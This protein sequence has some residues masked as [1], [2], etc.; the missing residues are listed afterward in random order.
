MMME[1]K[2]LRPWSTMGTVMVAMTTMVMV[3]PS[4]ATRTLDTCSRN[5]S[6]Q[7]LAC[8]VVKGCES[9]LGGDLLPSVPQNLHLATVPSANG[10]ALVLRVAWSLP[11]DASV[12]SVTGFCVKVKVRDRHESVSLHFPRPPAEQRDPQGRPWSFTYS[13]FSV[14]PGEF[15]YVSVHSQPYVESASANYT[16]PVCTDPNLAKFPICKK[17]TALVSLAVNATPGR[18]LV[19]YRSFD[20]RPEYNV[21]LCHLTFASCAGAAP[22]RTLTGSSN[23]SEFIIEQ[24]MPCLCVEVYATRESSLRIQ[25]CPFENVTAEWGAL[26][27]SRAP[28]GVTLRADGLLRRCVY[29]VRATLLVRRGGRDT[30]V[31]SAT[32]ERQENGSIILGFALNPEVEDQGE[33]CVMLQADKFYAPSDVVCVPRWRWVPLLALGAVVLAG[34][35]LTALGA[36]LGHAPGR[37]FGGAKESRM[38][39]LLHAHEDGADR[40]PSSLLALVGAL[41][42]FLRRRC[43]AEV[44]LDAWEKR[45]VARLGP[46]P[47]LAG[48]LERCQLSGGAVVVLASGAARRRWD[49]MRGLRHPPAGRGGAGDPASSDDAGGATEL[50]D[51]FTPALRLLCEQDAA[52]RSANVMVAVCV[53][54]GDVPSCL[55]SARIFRLPGDLGRLSAAIGGGGSVRDGGGGRRLR[56]TPEGAALLAEISKARERASGRGGGA[57]PP[58]ATD[59]AAERSAAGADFPGTAITE[60]KLQ[61]W[62]FLPDPSG[63]GDGETDSAYSSLEPA[64]LEVGGFRLTRA[65]LLQLVQQRS[66]KG[67][68][69]PCPT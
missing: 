37:F 2:R 61:M 49:E 40:P 62:P 51:L 16:V 60:T 59:A 42:T 6:Q 11:V 25:K 26:R 15:V 14:S 21:R 43:G 28:G 13:C 10:K 5:C 54:G 3:I 66:E 64:A 1:M 30:A 27:L 17:W 46:G 31:D 39:L 9:L 52:W 41:A 65:E 34:A 36:S 24:A 50:G 56:E 45:E 69:G 4:L 19:S 57:T 22:I 63:G 20:P 38:V 55:R 47:W 53:D 18:L 7:G 44:A 33:I 68:G 12:R 67:R 23:S 58:L 32:A 29:E 48:R 8:T 35:L